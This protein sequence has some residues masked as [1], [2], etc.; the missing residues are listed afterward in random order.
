MAE[1]SEKS[2]FFRRSVRYR[3][4]AIALVP[5]LV[6]L[7]VL[8][9]IGIDRWNDRFDAVTIA[10]VNDDLTIA[11][12]YLSRI[13]ENT[14][15]R[16]V[17]IGESERFRQLLRA[18][19]ESDRAFPVYLEATA[20]RG[21]FDFLYVVADD[22]EILAGDKAATPATLRWDWPVVV[23]ALAGRSRT[24]IDVFAGSELS[25]L[26]PQ[27]AER[28]RV[29]IVPVVRDGAPGGL[30]ETRGLV[31]QS[32]ATLL[33]PD[34][35]RAALVGGILLNRNLGFVDAINDLIYH[36]STQPDGTQGTA[37]LFLDDIRVSTNVRLF[38]D[39]R[40]IGTRVSEEVRSTVLDQGKT[41]LDSA[42]VVND[43]YVSAYEP[44]VDSY[45]RRVGMLYAGFVEAP[46]AKVKH[47]T[48]LTMGVAF[49]PAV[50]ATV[51]LFLIWARTI[52]RPLERMKET[53]ARVEDGDLAARTG[54]VENRDEIGLVASELDRLLDGIQT[55]DAELRLWNDELS[56]RAEQRAL[57]LRDTA[58]RLETTTR[59]LVM[60]EKLAAI[61]EITAGVAHEINNPIAVMQG[62]LEIIRDMMGPGAEEAKTEF[63]L[64]NQ[65]MNRITE[66]VT[67]L[68]QFA[69]PQ[70]YAGFTEDYA[71]ADVISD[72]LPLVQHLLKKTMITVERE[73]R[74][75]RL[76]RM[77]RTEL[78]QV[79]VN[80]I[81]N[82]IH[83]M[84]R[85]G[86]LG[87]RTV[88]AAH[89]GVDGVEIEVS[90]T[91]AGMT[92]D[93]MGR[94]F[95]P[96]FTTKSREGTG[97]GLSISQMLMSQHGGKITVRSQPG[98]GTTFKVWLPATEDDF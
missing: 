34:G 6:V 98:E 12:Q 91:G 80:L 13:L 28:A 96:F 26:S 67:K 97:L 3:L 63:R 77:S 1:A 31:L 39:R 52:F 55:R 45:G 69:K 30:V 7:P 95:D 72:T 25:A 68:L 54:A 36:G 84:P 75:L 87:L 76:I 94:I 90:D 4:L 14:E 49:L 33:L 66:I 46:F 35:R 41:W 48:W 82:A 44:I 16:L 15:N 51:P 42:F 38:G 47:E 37:T 65:Q 9:A 2:G 89:G 81:V 29:E 27:L 88:D 59:Q 74:A 11:R 60:S 22:G 53:I 50:L 64:I 5:M 93:V 61:G 58:A 70:E 32:A 86:R 20:Q 57:E 10:K 18:G 24:A 79:L 78:Q 40:A 43:W 83:A 73:D 8:L 19:N 62:N 71:P 56:Q 21:G 92:P 85:G 17:A 23:S